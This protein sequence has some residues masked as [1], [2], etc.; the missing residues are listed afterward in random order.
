MLEKVTLASIRTLTGKM[1]ISKG[2]YFLL[3]A[4]A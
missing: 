1:L 2:P 3:S 4:R